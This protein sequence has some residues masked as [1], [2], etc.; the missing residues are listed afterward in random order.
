LS[1]SIISRAS[2]EANLVT[3]PAGCRGN[4]TII[5]RRVGSGAAAA[6][7]RRAVEEQLQAR[8]MKWFRG[9]LVFQAHRLVFHSTLGS[10]VIEKK[11]AMRRAVR[12]SSS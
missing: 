1:H 11:K 6:A 9:G 4:E 2:Y 8:N 12:P 3:Y 7:M 5:L 10:R